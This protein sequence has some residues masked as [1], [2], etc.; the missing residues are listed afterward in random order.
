[1]FYVF[2][3]VIINC[4]FLETPLSYVC[5][6][7]NL[8]VDSSTNVSAVSGDHF[9]EKTNN[10]IVLFNI[11]FQNCAI[12]P[13]G[14]ASFFPNIEN[15]SVFFSQLQTISASD[16]QVFPNLKNLE[17]IGNLI[18]NLPADL[19]AFTPSIELLTLSINRIVNV[20]ANILD[21]LTKLQRCNFDN[22]PCLSSNADST[23]DPNFTVFKQ[24][25][26]ANCP[27]A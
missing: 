14:I 25:L 6:V 26:A 22:N 19:F 15:L 3:V 11:A 7:K 17:L 24:L 12:L 21:S 1:M 20:G 5:D 10:D 18:E 9:P 4:Q 2:F 16:L 23:N 27:P 8:N 13:K